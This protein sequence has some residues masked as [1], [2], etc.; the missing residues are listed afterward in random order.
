M[1]E[2]KVLWLTGQKDYE[3]RLTGALIDADEVYDAVYVIFIRTWDN[4]SCDTK[5]EIPEKIIWEDEEYNR[6]RDMSEHDL[7]AYLDSLVGQEGEYIINDYAQVGD[8]LVFDYENYEFCSLN[9]W[10]TFK[11]YDYFCNSNSK[12]I[13]LES[14]EYGYN[15][16]YELEITDS[17][18]LDYLHGNSTNFEY[19]GMGEHAKLHKVII[20]GDEN[21]NRILWH[22]WSQWQ[23]SELDSGCLL[24][25]DE[26]LD[27]LEN[28]P[29]L[30]EITV[31][32]GVIEDAENK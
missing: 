16:E 5:I 7:M 15:E 11:A 24:T 20:D 26:A 1:A 31:W 28:H 6:L 29:E 9:D 22:E 3:D 13:Y 10:D 27:R 23:G 12:T 19:G 8:Y 25:V 21:D 30:E 18:N 17:Y 32:L 2:K 14:D 4:V